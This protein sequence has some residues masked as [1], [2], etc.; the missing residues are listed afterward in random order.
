MTMRQ[1]IEIPASRKVHFDIVLPET[2]PC[3]RTDVILNF[4]ITPAPDGGLTESTRYQPKIPLAK[5]TYKS[6]IEM[7]GSCNGDDTIE[8]YFAR[9]EA[10]KTFEDQ[11]YLRRHGSPIS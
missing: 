10:E 11:Q 1:T 8:E 5:R 6:L 2:V 3:G 9:K 4:P 7:I